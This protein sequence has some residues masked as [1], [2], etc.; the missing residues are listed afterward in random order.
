MPSFA[1]WLAD[2]DDEHF[3]FAVSTAYLNYP[4]LMRKN[5]I[6]INHNI[7]PHTPRVITGNSYEIITK[8]P[9]LRLALECI[10]EM[11]P[12]DR[13][14]GPMNRN[15]STRGTIPMN[16]IDEYAMVKCFR[17]PNYLPDWSG[18]VDHNKMCELIRVRN[19]ISVLVSL[20]D[21]QLDRWTE[22]ICQ[23]GWPVKTEGG[24]LREFQAMSECIDMTEHPHI[25]NCTRPSFVEWY[26][27]KPDFRWNT[28]YFTKFVKRA[29][30]EL[31]DPAD[32]IARIAARTN[33]DVRIDPEWSE[34]YQ[35][36]LFYLASTFLVFRQAT[37]F[38]LLGYRGRN[39]YFIFFS[40]HIVLLI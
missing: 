28:A 38:S 16:M 25:K 23:T 21:N 30:L 39:I 2:Y 36:P 31:A 19:G 10:C 26:L 24:T 12:L 13:S 7:S 20:P 22:Y 6:S 5:C 8:A 9:S 15:V 18:G 37:G 40:P 33:F 27:A 11:P 32:L 29:S 3:N 17:N 35:L 34:H 1:L 4:E 14:L